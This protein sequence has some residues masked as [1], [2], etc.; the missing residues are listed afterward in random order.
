LVVAMAVTGCTGGSSGERGGSAPRP[1]AT[2]IDPRCRAAL[3][4]TTVQPATSVPEPCQDQ[5]FRAELADPENAAAASLGADRALRLARSLCAYV[6][7][8]P[9]QSNPPSFD[10]L[11]T[12][13]ASTWKVSKKAATGISRAARVLCPDGISALYS[14]PGGTKPLEV[15][16]RVGGTGSASVVYTSGDDS[17]TQEQV[18]APWQRTVKA[19][20]R[21]VISILATPDASAAGAMTCTI[22][23]DGQKLD[24]QSSADPDN[25]GI[26]ACSVP[27][28]IA[29]R[30]VS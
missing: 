7:T 9:T 28:A 21:G 4:S 15:T 24:D 22:T 30:A 29:R 3:P 17:F 14:L 23:I 11:M 25:G 5:Q 27:I 6:A 1:T 10:D 19:T 2:T 16:Y 20:S 12:S 18:T 13:N 26:A 8:L